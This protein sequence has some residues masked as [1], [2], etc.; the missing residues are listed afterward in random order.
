MHKIF[1]QRCPYK[2]YHLVKGVYLRKK[3]KKEDKEQKQRSRLS[4]NYYALKMKS[5]IKMDEQCCAL[6]ESSFLSWKEREE[7]YFLKCV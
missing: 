7:L 5:T 3:Y 2:I 1:G 4:K 6:L